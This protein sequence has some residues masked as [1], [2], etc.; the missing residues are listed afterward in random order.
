M[1]LLHCGSFKSPRK[2]VISDDICSTFGWF[3][4]RDANPSPNLQSNQI[5]CT[6]YYQITNANGLGL[7]N[8]INISMG[9]LVGLRTTIAADRY[10]L[11]E[12]IPSSLQNHWVI[13]TQLTKQHV[14]RQFYPVSTGNCDISTH[15]YKV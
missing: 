15:L 7:N 2:T 5:C 8:S 4:N 6:P 13:W 11:D 1:Q 12:Q 14:I 3:T 9:K 10:N